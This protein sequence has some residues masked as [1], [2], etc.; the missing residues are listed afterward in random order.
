[1]T[2]LEQ[3]AALLLVFSLLG[4]AV[5][6]LGRGRL[7]WPFGRARGRQDLI[8]LVA[9]RALTAQHTRHLVRLAGRTVLIATFP[10]GIGFPPQEAAFE[11]ELAA[12]IEQSGKP[13]EK[14]R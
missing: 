10:G 14:A 5:L 6:A 9:T 13:G 3:C 7:R 8:E 1:M 2:L 4:L 12:A 11:R